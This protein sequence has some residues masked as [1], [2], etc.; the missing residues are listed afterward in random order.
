MKVLKQLEKP[1]QP[2]WLQFQGPKQGMRPPRMFVQL[3]V[4][5]GHAERTP[6]GEAEISPGFE[7][8]HHHW[9]KTQPPNLPCAILKSD[10]DGK[11]Y[12]FYPNKSHRP[13][14]RLLK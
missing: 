1:E 13:S 14:P 6:T 4:Q 3:E 2:S 9:N 11:R 10:S 5:L 8:R 7:L 12:F